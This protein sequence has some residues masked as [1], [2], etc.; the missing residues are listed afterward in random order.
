VKIRLLGVRGSTPA[1]GADFVRYGGH[2]SC[3]AITPSGESDPTLLLDAGT[4]IR[5]VTELLSG[6]AFHG[7]ILLTHLHWD[8]VCGL[9]FFGAGD[10][11][12]SSVDVH[13]PAQL[14]CS[15]RDLLARG[16]SPP[17]F[18]IGP[19][20]LRGNWTFRAEEPGARRIA[21]FEVGCA[22]VAHKGGRTYGYRVSDAHGAIAYL[23]DHNPARA[24][25]DREDPTVVPPSLSAEVRSC[26]EAGSSASARP[27]AAASR[28]RGSL[29]RSA[30]RSRR[31]ASSV[32]LFPS[33]RAAP[34]RTQGFGE[35]RVL[36]RRARA[37]GSVIDRPNPSRS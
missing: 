19:E 10:H 17:S 22:D 31:T 27:R 18:P 29:V 32:L 1:P 36:D 26:S 12:A 24:R 21:G 13:L 25:S 33:R 28:T 3:V 23:P 2:T 34:R 20:D 4:G 37:A 14:R 8:H 11:P 6:P 35:D 7:S 5:S 9:P 15:G 16:M 30:V